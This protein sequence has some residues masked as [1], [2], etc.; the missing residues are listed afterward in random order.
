MGESEWKVGRGVEAGETIMAST[1]ITGE[2]E[3][4]LDSLWDC[5]KRRALS[6]LSKATVSFQSERPETHFFLSFVPDP[7]S[8]LLLPPV[9]ALNFL[10]PTTTPLLR[11]TSPPGIFRVDVGFSAVGQTHSRPAFRQRLQSGFLQSKGANSQPLVA[12]S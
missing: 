12:L 2:A 7:R 5:T 6:V 4:S 3:T 10:A 1:L 9:S 8:L 11:T